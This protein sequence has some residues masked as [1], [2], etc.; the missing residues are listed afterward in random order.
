MNVDKL[1]SH[2]FIGK[3]IDI[4]ILL[5]KHTFYIVDYYLWIEESLYF[6]EQTLPH[7]VSFSFS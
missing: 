6:I 4:L 2:M 5:T 1:S 7:Y 3:A